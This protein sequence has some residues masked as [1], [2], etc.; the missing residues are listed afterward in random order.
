M[1]RKFL[2][3]ILLCT[4]TSMIHA[5]IRLPRLISNGMVLQRDIPLKIWGWASAGEKVT[6]QIENEK[7][8]YIS[9][10]SADGDWSITLPER[11]AGGPFRMT[12]TGKNQIV[13][14]DILFGDI[15]LCSGQSNMEQPMSARL[16]YKY[17][18]EVAT[19]NNNQIRHFLVPDKADFKTARTDLESGSWK[20]VTPG[21]IVEFTAVGYFFAK[22]LYARYKI[23]IGLINAAL[24]GSPAEAWISEGSLKQFPPYF[25]EMQKWKSEDLIKETETRDRSA[26]TAW[27]NELNQSDKG[28]LHQWKSLSFNDDDWK[29]V[30]IPEWPGTEK[31]S[32]A[33]VHWFR[34]EIHVPASMT[35][36]PAKIELG[37]MTDA[38]SVFINGRFAGS[39][40][41]QYPAR[42]YELDSSFLQPG[43]NAIVIRLVSNSRNAAFG[44]AKP[45]ELTTLTDT[46]ILAGEWKYKQGA[47]ANQNYPATTGI[48]NKPGG[49]HNAMIAP[50]TK[51]AIKGVI[52]YQGETNSNY[53]GNYQA[54]MKSL[55]NDWRTKW[56]IHF[57]FLFV[58]LPN[59]ME[60]K[61]QPQEKSNWA[62]LREQQLK[63]LEV[64]NTG[65][66]T[67][68]DL[69]T[70]ND[71]HP[72]NKHDVGYRLSLLARKLTYGEKNLVASGPIFRS[73]KC[74][75]NKLIIQFTNTGAGLIVK[76]GKEL[77][78]FAIAGADGKY[79]WARAIIRNNKVIAWH[80]EIPEPMSIRYA[81]A[82]NPEGA[83]LYNK[84]GLPASPFQAKKKKR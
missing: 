57:P 9:Q 48:R 58:Q 13:I 31:P 74:D 22:E 67:A 75:G 20:S 83:N 78:H 32:S 36:M 29:T 77:G 63:T 7:T 84:E 61:E 41:Y 10:T 25:D 15:W 27:I 43:K 66:V 64:A 79:K 51:Y 72:E 8:T 26:T 12:I 17:A 35:G 3:T 44:P 53:P 76:D 62:E 65:M 21:N 82:D 42:R 70:W 37:R 56:N 4:S 34:K 28:M 40:T 38:D 46:I 71:L 39:T 6:L 24:G 18:N 68:I 59:Y 45:Y 50:L 14:D 2:Y 1:L 52:W 73:M 19:A 80:D 55:I 47:S 49:L 11:K 69:G 23:P 54:L 81:W 30:T 60:A 16:K 5:Q 33:G